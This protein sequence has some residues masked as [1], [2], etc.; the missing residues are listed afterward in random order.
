MIQIIVNIII[1]NIWEKYRQV[2]DTPS[3]EDYQYLIMFLYVSK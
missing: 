2:I 3:N 1:K